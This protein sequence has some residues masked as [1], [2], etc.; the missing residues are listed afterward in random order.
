MPIMTVQADPAELR[1]DGTVHVSLRQFG[2]DVIIPV[3]IPAKARAKSGSGASYARDWDHLP[4]RCIQ[5][6][7]AWYSHGCRDS[8]HTKNELRTLLAVPVREA[9]FM[10]RISELLACGII[11]M[12]REAKAAPHDTQDAPVYRLDLGRAAVVLREGGKL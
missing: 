5:I 10:A 11:E 9:P 4:E 7:A 1:G 8:W 6:L 12:S 2:L 3:V